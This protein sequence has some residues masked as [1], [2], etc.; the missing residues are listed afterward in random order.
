M[1]CPQSQVE[2]DGKCQEIL[3][4]DKNILMKEPIFKELLHQIEESIWEIVVMTTDL[5]EV[6]VVLIREEDL[7]MKG[8]IP[9]EIEDLQEEEDHKMMEDPPIIRRCQHGL[10][11]DHYEC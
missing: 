7:L 9:T 4:W 5:T 1:D 10:Q 2:I 6:E 3:G 8:D 11:D